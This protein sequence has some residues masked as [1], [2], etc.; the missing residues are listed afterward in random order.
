MRTV[1]SLPTPW[2]ADPYLVG[3]RADA[4]L[5]THASDDEACVLVLDDHP[6]RSLVG[7]GR[8]EAV[9]RLLTQS[10]AAFAAHQPQTLTVER[11]SW[12]HLD[13]RTQDQ[14]AGPT[15]TTSEWDWMSTRAPLDVTGGAGAPGVLVERFV[16]GP[17]TDALVTDCLDRAH[18]IASTLPGDPRLT[19]WWGVRESD[20]LPAGAGAG[21]AGG[22]GSGRS[23]HA[24]ARLVA[25]VG[26]LD[27]YPGAAPHL[28]SLGVDPGHR[29]AGLAGAVL[30]AAVDDGLRRVPV[31]GDPM[32]H[33]GLYATNDLARRV[34]ARLGFTLDHQFMSVRRAQV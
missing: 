26:A 24:G 8:P 14:L 9:A 2:D 11:G 4:E 16:P 15:A 25:V 17:D 5:R 34:Y 22:V 6:G 23:A 10:A 3:E 12:E 1:G 19:A 31:V 18:P 20:V 13:P 33:L 7:I 30:A 21:T 28:V 27:L 32:V 29:G